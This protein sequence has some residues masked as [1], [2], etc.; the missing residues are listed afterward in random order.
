MKKAHNVTNP[1]NC[2]IIEMS[3]EESY[4]ID[5]EVDLLVIERI[6]KKRE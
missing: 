4:D 6:I 3:D 5:S 2:S 1:H